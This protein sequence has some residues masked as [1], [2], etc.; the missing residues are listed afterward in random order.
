M[1]FEKLTEQFLNLAEQFFRLEVVGTEFLSGEQSIV[2]ANHSGFNGMDGLMLAHILRKY[3]KQQ[4]KMVTHPFWF[5]FAPFRAFAKDYGFIEA[6]GTQ[7]MENSLRDGDSLAIFP[8]G[9]SGNFKNS[10][11]MYQLQ[12]FRSGLV[13]L[14][15]KYDLPVVP[16]TILGAEESAL[17]FFKLNLP[18]PFHG[19]LKVPLPF[20]LLPM[21]TKWRIRFYPAIPASKYQNQYLYQS[22]VVKKIQRLWKKR[23]QIYLYREL[24]SRP[25]LFF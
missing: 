11:Q 19:G 1:S 3:S 18:G 6:T 22:Q 13:R 2:F 21:P 17:S 4:Y 8:E 23:L 10:L 5:Q 12:E 15:L 7:S 20:N 9:E 16:C 14:A 25:G 24:K